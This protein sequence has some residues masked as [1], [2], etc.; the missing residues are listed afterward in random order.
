MKKLLSI[1][2][3]AVLMGFSVVTAQAQEESLDTLLEVPALP[4]IN[5]V[6]MQ[7]SEDFLPEPGSWLYPF[8]PSVPAP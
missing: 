2:A 6:E 5:M 3:V 7:E 8:P 1:G 4:E